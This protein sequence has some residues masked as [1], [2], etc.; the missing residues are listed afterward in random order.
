MKIYCN[1]NQILIKEKY[2][3]KKMTTQ[4]QQTKLS[5]NKVSLESVIEFLNVVNDSIEY[6]NRTNI[7]EDI[8][9]LEEYTIKLYKENKSM[10]PIISQMKD[11]I[12]GKKDVIVRNYKEIFKKKDVTVKEVTITNIMR[13]KLEEN[14][15][16]YNNSKEKLRNSV[17][18]LNAYMAILNSIII[19][20]DNDN[21][22]MKNIINLMKMAIRSCETLC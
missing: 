10:E 4:Q 5:N 14:E 12:T 19:D 22:K 21:I 15:L 13:E 17:G 16:D 8:T 7:D 6:I 1:T 3:N 2:I 9:K 18:N 11:I 20:L